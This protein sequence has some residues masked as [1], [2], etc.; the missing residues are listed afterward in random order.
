M[1][2]VIDATKP[3]KVRTGCGHVVIRKMREST[4][5]V[6]WTEETIIEAPNGRPCEACESAK[7]DLME[8]R[9]LID[10]ICAGL[11][12]LISYNVPSGTDSGDSTSVNAARDIYKMADN[13]RD[14][15]N[16]R[17]RQ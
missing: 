12:D 16:R 17:V 1:A 11:V 2:E 6:P 10:A 3:Y 13:L 15:L 9:M 5:G 8:E 7:A 4:A 14:R